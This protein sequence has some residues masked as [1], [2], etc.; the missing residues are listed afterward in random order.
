[1]RGGAFLFAFALAWCV[2]SSAFAERWVAA[3]ATS[4]QIPESRN[5]LDPAD[6]HDATLRQVI[7]TTMGGDHVRVH[8][9]NVF[10]TA[11][12][13]ISAAT[14]ARGTPGAERIDASTLTTL[15]FA[16][17][18]DVTIPTGAEYIS[19]PVAFATPAFSDIA[20][21]L[22][23]DDAPA[24]Q[25]SHPG[26]RT[27]SF[28]GPGD[29]TSAPDFHAAKSVAH[30]YQI[31]A[32]DVLAPDNAAAISVIGDSITDGRGSTTNGNDRWTDQL[33]ARLQASPHTR[34][35]SVLNHGIGGNRLLNE[36]LGPNALSRFDRDVLTEAGVRYVIVL[37]GINDL[38]GLPKD[39]TEAD[40]AA[41]VAHM[42]GAYQQMITRAH[43]HGLKI[44]G[45]TILPDMG[46]PVY[47][48]TTANEADR[49][50]VNTWIR[51]AGHFDAVIDFDAVM[52]DP[53]HPDQMLPAYDTGDH[54]HPNPAGY[55]AMAAA[56]PLSLF[57]NAATDRA[58]ALNRPR[59]HRSTHGDRHHPGTT[60]SP[61]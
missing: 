45:A 44:F 14:I 34:Q 61:N 49:Q 15:T 59:H 55:H 47:T 19:D 2:T 25:T 33:A 18:R 3:W 23:Y 16:G 13:H 26:S 17:Q 22:H 6:F 10:G 4:Q 20:I 37:E 39:A 35:L 46:T 53:A 43:A 54:L 38:G 24:Q 60:P 51:A 5:A 12:L 30:W 42:I 56:V 41:L 31:A 32:L 7:H 57:T 11:A 52:R 8:I 40:H 21:S 9:S 58:G 36:G 48:P 28:I 29:L 1:M 50:A 27:D